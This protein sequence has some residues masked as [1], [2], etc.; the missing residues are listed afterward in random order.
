MIIDFGLAELDPNYIGRLEEKLV[1][2][3]ETNDPQLKT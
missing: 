3:R 1:K 2:M